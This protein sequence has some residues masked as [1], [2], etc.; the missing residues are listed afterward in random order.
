MRD[1]KYSVLDVAEAGGY[2]LG[3]LRQGQ[4]EDIVNVKHTDGLSPVQNSLN[5]W[6]SITAPHS[7]PGPESTPLLQYSLRLIGTME[8]CRQKLF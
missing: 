3:G 5:T 7:N 4:C 6:K 1:A 2:L 8:R